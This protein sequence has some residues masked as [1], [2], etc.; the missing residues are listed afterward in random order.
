MLYNRW[1]YI[2]LGSNVG[3]RKRNLRHAALMLSKH[4]TII[5]SSNIYE[6]APW[7]YKKQKKFCNQV[8][9]VYCKLKPIQLLNITKVIERKLG[10]NK[11][12]KWGPRT[13]DID[14]IAYKNTILKRKDLWLPHKFA[15]ER[16][17]VVKPLLELGARIKL[18]NEQLDK[19][20][21]RLE[22]SDFLETC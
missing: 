22:G 13:I 15:H 9:K 18:G 2:G 3:N 1:V 5:K 16:L 17:F 20:L 4:V 14:I 7:G 12:F 11:R 21:S 6:S 19:I 10:K 8:L